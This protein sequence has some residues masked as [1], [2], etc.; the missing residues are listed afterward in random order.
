MKKLGFLTLILALIFVSTINAKSE[1]NSANHITLTTN[2][3]NN[4]DINIT[5]EGFVFKQYLGKTVLLNFF[6][7][8]CPPCIIEMPHLIELQK[9]HK[10]DLQ[11][12]A[13]QVQMPMEDKEL[14]AF[15]KKNKV[16]Y[17]VI[18]LNDAWDIVSF[19]KANTNWGGQIPFMM[20]F[21]K[22]G[23]LKNQYMGVVA[24]EKLISDMNK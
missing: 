7:P 12:I 23:N 11:V 9:E 17:P 1:A 2:K 5:K 21:D 22:N 18:N 13:V 16:N 15:I 20:M 10:D 24:N 6:G 4:I 8:M 14:A 19:V 3:G